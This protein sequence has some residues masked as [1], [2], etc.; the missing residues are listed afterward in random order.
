M[1][2]YAQ[3]G[4]VACVACRANEDGR[5]RA[6]RQKA[7]RMMMGCHSRGASAPVPAGLLR[8][9]GV[10]PKRARKRGMPPDGLLV[11]YSAS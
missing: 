9:A 3:S 8:G 1:A 4:F 11:S 10:V 6:A 7:H 5:S 2:R